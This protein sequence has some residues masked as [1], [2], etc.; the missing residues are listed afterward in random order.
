MSDFGTKQKALIIIP[1][2]QTKTLELD[3]P[4]LLYPFSIIASIL[5]RTPEQEDQ[6]QS[7]RAQ[8]TFLQNEVARVLAQLRALG[9]APNGTSCST[10]S[11]NL[12]FGIRGAQVECLQQFLKNQGADVYPE[13]LVTGYFGPLTRAAVIRFQ[14][15]Y[16]AE[17]LAPL[18]LQNGTGF[19]GQ[20]TRAKMNELAL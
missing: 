8:L 9:A 2:L 14:E 11:A 19:V 5:E 4:E 12:A 16:A 6:I 17:V 1:T 10:F 13:G 15:K 7:L 18:G 20:R 3:S